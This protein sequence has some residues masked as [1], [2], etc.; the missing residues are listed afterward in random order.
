MGTSV[1]IKFWML[2]F[3]LIGVWNNYVTKG[4]GIALPAKSDSDVMLCLQIIRDLQSIH[5]LCINPIRR[6][7]LTHK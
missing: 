5:H 4:E 3:L 1:D 6:I 7:G 2:I